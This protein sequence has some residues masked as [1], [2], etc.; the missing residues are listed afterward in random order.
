M[1]F[2]STSPLKLSVNHKLSTLLGACEGRLLFYCL[3]V[4]RLCYLVNYLINTTSS[5]Y[6]SSIMMSPTV[7]LND[8]FREAVRRP[9]FPPWNWNV[10]VHRAALNTRNPA[11][12]CG[13]AL[14]TQMKQTLDKE[15]TQGWL[16]FTQC[17]IRTKSIALSVVVGRTTVSCLITTTRWLY[18]CYDGTLCT[19]VEISLLFWF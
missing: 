1:A 7:R 8:G 13:A 6:I 9:R 11:E 14:E 4:P 2:Y 10:N 12:P 17:C 15:A 19:A 3:C 18:G 5:C 16:H